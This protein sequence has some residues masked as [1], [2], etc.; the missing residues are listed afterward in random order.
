MFALFRWLPSA[1]TGSSFETIKRG[2]LHPL[3][4]P[5]SPNSYPSDRKLYSG[6]PLVGRADIA[7]VPLVLFTS[8]LIGM[9][10]ARSLHY[11]FHSWYFHQIP[12]LLV[13]GG[14]W[15]SRVLG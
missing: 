14:A 9:T 7:D 3:R 5:F 13:S 6:R 4:A 10:M 8:N 15:N 1:G 11:Q 2:L 12:F